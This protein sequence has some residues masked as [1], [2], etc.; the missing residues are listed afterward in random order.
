[1]SIVYGGIE[2][3]SGDITDYLYEQKLIRLKYTPDDQLIYLYNSEYYFIPQNREFCSCLLYENLIKILADNISPTLEFAIEN[4]KYRDDEWYLKLVILE[5]QL[6]EWPMY[7]ERH[8]Q[9]N[10]KYN[11]DTHNGF[12]KYW[13]LVDL[14][15]PS[16]NKINIPEFLLLNKNKQSAQ[17]YRKWMELLY[18]AEVKIKENI[19]EFELKLYDCVA[20]L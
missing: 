7:R 12:T 4:A 19:K 16:F 5:Q 14:V 20:L 10:K 13:E 15:A 1:M 8:I 9:Q 18:A 6:A 17:D 2:Y 11:T 3:K